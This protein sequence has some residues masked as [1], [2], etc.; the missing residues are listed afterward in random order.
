MVLRVRGARME[1]ELHNNRLCETSRLETSHHREQASYTAA[2][3][4]QRIQENSHECRFM[5]MLYR[6]LELRMPITI[7]M[8]DVLEQLMVIGIIE[9]I[10]RQQRK[11]RVDGE[12]FLLGDIVEIEQC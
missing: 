8:Y 1:S 10:N 2:E 6:S 12:W 4:H 3:H 11:F 9:D 7:R 5:I